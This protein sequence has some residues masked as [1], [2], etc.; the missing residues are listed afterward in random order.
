MSH[1]LFPSFA[2]EKILSVSSMFRGDTRN[3]SLGPQTAAQK[4]LKQRMQPIFF[5]AAIAG[6]CHKHV[7]SDERGQ[8]GGRNSLRVQ[9]GA[10]FHFNSIEERNP[11][12]VLLSLR[13][14]SSENLFGKIFKNIAL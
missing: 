11:H 6:H 4:T 8:D 1:R 10:G 12:Q 13:G 14:F 7:T 2:L 3:P 9:S 5:S